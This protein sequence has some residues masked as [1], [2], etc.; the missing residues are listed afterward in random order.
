MD[1]ARTKLLI[2][3]LNHFI[4]HC[5]NE[6]FQK[7]VQDLKITEAELEALSSEKIYSDWTIPSFAMDCIHNALDRIYGDFGE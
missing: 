7:Y 5:Q 3:E 4:S 1:E 2:N 6:V